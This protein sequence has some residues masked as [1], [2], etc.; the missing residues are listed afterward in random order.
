MTDVIETKPECDC[1]QTAVF[2]AALELTRLEVNAPLE[3]IRSSRKFE[4]N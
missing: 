4:L 1:E 2:H 3:L